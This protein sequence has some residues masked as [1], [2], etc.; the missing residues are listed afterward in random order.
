MIE[1]SIIQKGTVITDQH[2]DDIETLIKEVQQLKFELKAADET[3]EKSIAEL[4][5]ENAAL[6]AEIVQMTEDVKNILKNI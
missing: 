3:Y 2:I 6:K 5:L 1:S 4:K